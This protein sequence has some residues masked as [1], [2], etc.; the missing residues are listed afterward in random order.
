M[1][2]LSGEDDVVH[3]HLKVR[4]QILLPLIFAGIHLLAMGLTILTGDEN[5]DGALGVVLWNWPVFVLC[6]LSIVGRYICSFTPHGWV[7]FV[8]TGALIYAFIGF[9]IGT[10]IDRIR[11]LIA[12]RSR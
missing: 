9:V 12:R 3:E 4:L 11:A 7:V 10:V 5:G 1:P 2:S 8:L 6:K